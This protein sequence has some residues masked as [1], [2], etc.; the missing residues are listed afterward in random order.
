VSPRPPDRPL[1]ERIGPWV[2]RLPSDVARVYVREGGADIACA[3]IAINA[4]RDANL[5]DLVEVIEGLVE[6]AAKIL[7]INLVA[8]D[9]VDKTRTR[10]PLRVAPSEGSTTLALPE[11]DYGANPNEMI[12]VAIAHTEAVMSMWTQAQQ[13]THMQLTQTIA[14]LS[15]D[16][17]RERRARYA[18]EDRAHDAAHLARDAVA[19]ADEADKEAEPTRVLRDGVLTKVADAV[20]KKVG[21]MIDNAVTS[22][23]LSAMMG[24]GESAKTV[25]SI[26]DATH[27]EGVV[28]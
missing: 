22:G 19:A 20:S 17:S 27:V 26:V 11:K 23:A 18:A 14:Q 6:S 9:A 12:R 13:A 15:G 25:E 2:R 3:E 8:V 24:G 28:E 7:S 10:L 21:D 1:A 16:L 4:E 5:A